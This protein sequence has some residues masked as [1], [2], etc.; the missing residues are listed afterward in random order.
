VYYGYGVLSAP[1]PANAVQKVLAAIAQGKSWKR[2]G[3]EG[4]FEVV[5]PSW[6]SAEFL[7]PATQTRELLRSALDGSELI[8]AS[9]ML[10]SQRL[11]KTPYEI[12]KLRLASEISCFGLEAFERLVE[13]GVTGVELAA[14]VERDVMV[15]GTR[16]GGERVRGFAQVAVGP[17]ETAVGYRPNEISTLRPMKSG[18][19]ALLELGVVVD[20]YWA[21]RTRVRVAGTPTDEQIKIFDT[22]RRAQE[23]AVAA[24]RPGVSGAQVDEAARSEIRDAGYAADF[25]HVT[26]HGL[27]FRYHESSPIL[28]PNSATILEEGNLTSVEPGIYR[29]PAGGFRIED[30]VLVTKTGAEIFGPFPKNLV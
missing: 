1:D 13:I 16:K 29:L 20:G 17:E 10:Q 7:V 22:V 4:S 6:N 24:I 15:L 8:D 23:A 25:P 26:G 9:A 3:Y 28:A 5:A 12:G 14:A 27:G 11:R 30:D 18:D 19:V 21:D 2:I